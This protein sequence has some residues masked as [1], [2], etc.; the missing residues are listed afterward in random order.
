MK[1]LLRAVKVQV[2]TNSLASY[3][4]TIFHLNV[5][6]LVPQGITAY[7]GKVLDTLAKHHEDYL[8]DVEPFQLGFGSVLSKHLKS[9]SGLSESVNMFVYE[10]IYFACN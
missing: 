6:Y 3:I 10:G 7:L 2:H 5:Y 8:Q 9:I 4:I 1:H